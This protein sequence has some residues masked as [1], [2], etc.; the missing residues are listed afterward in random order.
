MKINVPVMLILQIYHYRIWTLI[1][2]DHNI[3]SYFEVWVLIR[4]HAAPVAIIKNAQRSN[5]FTGQ[6]MMRA[7]VC[8]T[9]VQ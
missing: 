5:G 9:I 1:T 4:V 6:E 7:Y 3:N 2:T 8:Y